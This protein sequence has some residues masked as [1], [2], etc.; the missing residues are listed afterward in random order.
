MSASY[1]PP[2]AGAQRP[3]DDLVEQAAVIERIL[4]HLALS[5]EVP[6]PRPACAPPL[7]FTEVTA[8]ARRQDRGDEDL[9]AEP[10][11]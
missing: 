11:N 3:N 2:A 8:D 1:T 4:R 6:D 7:R 10:D 5:T 9:Y